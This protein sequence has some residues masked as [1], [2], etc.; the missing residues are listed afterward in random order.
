MIV[1]KGP[2]T[3]SASSTMATG[4]VLRVKQMGVDVSKSPC[5]DVHSTFLILQTTAT[6][7]LGGEDMHRAGLLNLQL[8][9]KTLSKKKVFF[10]GAKIF[11]MKK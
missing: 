5:C 8:A 4:S 10:L 1:Q 3:K 7:T 11:E 6:L 9:S 2:E